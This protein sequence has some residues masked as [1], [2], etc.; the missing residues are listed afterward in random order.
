MASRDFDLN[1]E[2]PSWDSNTPI[3]WDA[4]GD[5]EG[6]AHDLDFH[7]VWDD[8]DDV[9]EEEGQHAH[10]DHAPTEGGLGGQ[11]GSNVRKRKFYYDEF[12]IAIY[13]EL[14]AKADPPVLHRGV[15][16]EVA[17]KFGVPLRVVQKIWRSGQDS[18]DIAGE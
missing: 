2:L 3:D 10:G 16:K 9:G 7:M 17:Q 4:I 14:L 8:G 6:P 11:Q 13:V 5:W 12:K 1:H 15:S 18:D